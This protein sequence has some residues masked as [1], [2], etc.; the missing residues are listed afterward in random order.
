MSVHY[1]GS[2]GGFSEYEIRAENAHLSVQRIPGDG[3]CLYHCIAQ[4]IGYSTAPELRQALAQVMEMYP[5]ARLRYDATV[6]ATI[7]SNADG[8]TYEDVVS[9]VR[10]G[11]YG[12]EAE[13][14]ILEEVTGENFMIYRINE[15]NRLVPFRPSPIGHA[16]RSYGLLWNRA[17][18]GEGG[19]HYDLILEF[20]RIEDDDGDMEDL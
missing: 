15:K 2:R 11:Q 17:E 4:A 7:T 20:N 18:T 9:G 8:K 13:L 1:S 12:G 3:N 5:D 19:N 6:R 10:R 14:A 16:S